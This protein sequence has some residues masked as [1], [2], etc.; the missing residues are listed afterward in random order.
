MIRTSKF[1]TCLTHVLRFEGVIP[2]KGLKGNVDHPKDPGGRTG[3]GI[4]QREYNEWLAG[5]G[6]A[7]KDVW[8]MS[9]N[10][11]DAIYWERYWDQVKGDDYPLPVSM[12]LFD[13]AVLNG[14]GASKKLAQKTVG[15]R[16]DGIIGPITKAA[17]NAVDKSEFLERFQHHRRAYLKTRPAWPTFGEGWFNRMDKL[18]KIV[19]AMIRL[20]SKS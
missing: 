5:R 15:V 19:A 12:L 7:A 4:L 14:V 1:K 2:E 6:R 10:D 3:S 13:T 9:D 16:Q 17:L 20:P 8:E 18:D 11:R